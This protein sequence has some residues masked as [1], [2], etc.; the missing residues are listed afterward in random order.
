MKTIKLMIVA[1]VLFFN[2]HGGACYSK[3]FGYLS[4]VAQLGVTK[5]EYQTNRSGPP[6]K[7]K[8]LMYLVKYIIVIKNNGDSSIKIPT[9]GF[10]GGGYSFGAFST[11]ESTNIVQ[12]WDISYYE[13]LDGKRTALV[14]AESDLKIV[15][16]K[17]NESVKITWTETLYHLDRL[18]QISIKLIIT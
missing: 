2:S 15:E 4:A 6:E 7:N 17:P 8:Q 1:I 5:Y 3:E 10:S 14:M 12:L 13:G 11:M 18:K 9:S 16:L